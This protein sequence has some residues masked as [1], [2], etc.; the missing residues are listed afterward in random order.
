MEW[1]AIVLPL[2]QATVEVNCDPVH[3]STGLSGHCGIDE[4]WIDRQYVL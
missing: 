1:T 2:D 3:T 4:G